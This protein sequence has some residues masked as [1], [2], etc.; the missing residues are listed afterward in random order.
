MN[1]SFI[2]LLRKIRGLDKGDLNGFLQA[3]CD[4]LKSEVPYY[5][6]VG[7]Y[8]NAPDQE[9]MLELGPYAGAAT[10]HVRIPYGKGICGQAAETGKPFIIQDVSKE[11][12]YLS[13]SADV[14]SE[15]VIPIK[16]GGRILGEVDIDSHDLN[17][18][19]SDDVEFLGKIAALVGSLL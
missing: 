17:P 10:D 13:C 3:I 9:Q 19:S 6:W 11:G 8:L 15:I 5:H 18:F 1:D 4:L 12:N 14:L 7:F 16:R 2:Q